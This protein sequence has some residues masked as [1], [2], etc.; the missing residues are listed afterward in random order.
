MSN[1]LIILGLVLFF[2]CFLGFFISL[3][4]VLPKA[5]KEGSWWAGFPFLIM[6]LMFVIGMVAYSIG[7]GI[8][9]RSTHGSFNKMR[10]G[11]R[12]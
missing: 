5:E 12:I 7:M 3:A 10:Q 2:F 8:K 6:G 11:I 9:G 1:F 4:I